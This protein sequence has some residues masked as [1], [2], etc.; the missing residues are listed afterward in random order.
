MKFVYTG[1]N[2]DI[3]PAVREYVEKRFARIGKFFYS[4]PEAAVTLSKRK[5]MQ[6]FEVTINFKG[7]FFRAEETNEDVFTAVDKAVD[8]IERQIRKNRTRLEKR[9]YGGAEKI[10]LGEYEDDIDEP[11]EFKIIRKKTVSSKPMN[12]EEAI[13][14]MNLLGHEFFVFID[15]GTYLTSVVYKRKDG[16]YGLLE[17]ER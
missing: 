16:D 3:K 17:L 14:Q 15:A 10:D 9:L 13:L 1:K 2:I 6:I 11:G 7:F 12:P 8:I 4:E 5:K